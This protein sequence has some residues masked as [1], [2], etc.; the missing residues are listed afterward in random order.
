ME[1][2]EVIKQHTVDIDYLDKNNLQTT[3]KFSQSKQNLLRI[4]N[5]YFDK[6]AYLTA[7]ISKKSNLQ[8]KI[9]TDHKPFLAPLEVGDFAP[10]TIFSVYTLAYGDIQVEGWENEMLGILFKKGLL[11][12]LFTRLIVGQWQFN[13]MNNEASLLRSL[14][15]K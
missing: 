2:S 5:S 15:F 10:N 11:S 1:K 8:L 6:I 4:N 9:N 13:R 3:I 12:N 7:F 14:L